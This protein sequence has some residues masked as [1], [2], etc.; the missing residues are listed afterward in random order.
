M[1]EN[2][3]TADR[4]RSINDKLVESTAYDPHMWIWYEGKYYNR[5]EYETLLHEIA[6]D[7]NGV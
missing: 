2:K 5:N 3:Q 6:H 7:A 4:L 1:P